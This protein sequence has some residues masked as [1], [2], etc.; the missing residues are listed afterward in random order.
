MRSG[1]SQGSV[2]G[3]LLFV[4]FINDI[5]KAVECV[6]IIKKLAYDTK[7]GQIVMFPTDSETVQTSFNNLSS[8]SDLSVRLVR[9]IC[10]VGQIY[11]G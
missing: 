1:V 3:P 9:S 7:V 4:I 5:D 6:T 8:W 2:L 11:G 10:P